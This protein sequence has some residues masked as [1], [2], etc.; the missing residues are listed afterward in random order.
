M[1]RERT[2]PSA[3]A[4]ALLAAL[5]LGAACTSTPASRA[6]PLAAESTRA[7]ITVSAELPVDTP[8]P[9]TA[10]QSRPLAAYSGTTYLVAWLDARAG[11]AGRQDL[12]VTRL[13]SA[14]APLGAGAVVAT[15]VGQIGVA[16]DGADFLL[17]WTEGASLRA[18]RVSGATGAVLDS[19][20]LTLT[21]TMV[22]VVYERQ[23]KEHPVAVAFDGTSYVLAWTDRRYAAVGG[24][25]IFAAR[26]SPAG[27]LLDPAGILVSSEPTS[28]LEPSA[29]S[30][31]GETLLTWLDERNEFFEGTDVYGARV[32]SAGT[33][34]DPGGL[35]VARA[36]GR[37]RY[38]STAWNGATWTVTFSD[39]RRTFF[40]DEDIYMARLSS[41]G[42]LLTPQ[43]SKVAQSLAGG[44]GS[45]AV[46]A[47]GD[48]ETELA[49]WRQAGSPSRIFG[50][51]L[52]VKTGRV[53]DPDGV[54]LV[55]EPGD[56]R[57]PSLA[58]GPSPGKTALF[59]ARYVSEVGGQRVMARFVEPGAASGAA[60][61]EALACRSRH[62]RDGVCC[63]EPCDGLCRRCGADGKCVAVT[64]APDD[65]TCAGAVRCDATGACAKV[66]GATCS[67][68]A[69]C[70]SGFCADGFCCNAP[71]DG[72]CDT[73]AATPGTCSLVPAGELGLPSCSPLRCSGREAACPARCATDEACA[74][75]F[76][77]DRPTGA[78]VG[79]SVCSDDHT[80][81]S[82]DGEKTDCR[83]Y[84]CR[85][86]ACLSS[87]AGVTDC[88]F[89]AACTEEARCIAPASAAGAADCAFAPARRGRGA[90][91]LLAVAALALLMTRKGRRA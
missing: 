91:P 23:S 58:P 78:C 65:D 75:G 44:A 73:C 30:R 33:V 31:P 69:E 29:A 8:T 51:W 34:L 16:S 20:A 17:A 49:V 87:C 46:L 47:A 22:G 3:F 56:A 36:P 66:D 35:V 2:S 15:S 67:S 64:S 84:Q 37:Q 40:N 63:E 39:T 74:D 43:G 1:H 9:A 12:Y 71:C 11:V 89:P 42:A 70:A 55:S 21:T 7:A 54:S 60:C 77:C 4:V 72:A 38:A 41:A 57:D 6:E 24:W 79:G 83:P 5:G 27:A 13:S 26:V 81:R 48:G 76:G 80:S 86:G 88:A 59:Y 32:S 61:S 68:P 85:A 90:A 62:C 28:Q 45:S 19:P 18:A 53:L 10:A 82:S 14:G 50:A 52:D 25:D